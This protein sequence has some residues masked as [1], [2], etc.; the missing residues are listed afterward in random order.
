MMNA[1]HFL[2][3]KT[4]VLTQ[5]L[6]RIP[7][8]DEP[9]KIKGRKGK[10]VSVDQISE[11]TYQVQVIFEKEIKKQTAVINDPRKKKK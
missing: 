10:I 2:E 11:N 1:V 3:N 4:T 6:K 7:I 5:A 8:V 9:I